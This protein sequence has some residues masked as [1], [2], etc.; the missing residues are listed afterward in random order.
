MLPAYR[1]PEACAG[2]E[3]EARHVFV[4]VPVDGELWAALAA[5]SEHL[6]ESK[7]FDLRDAAVSVISEQQAPI[8][9]GQNMEEIQ[10]GS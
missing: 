4:L 6:L 9:A 8:P 1:V 7:V 5:T 2:V 3:N 10:G